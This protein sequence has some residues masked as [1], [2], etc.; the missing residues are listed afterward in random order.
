MDSSWNASS[1]TTKQIKYPGTQSHRHIH[2]A[3]KQ[4]HAISELEPRT[5]GVKLLRSSLVPL[6]L[7]AW[8]KSE[9]WVEA[10]GVEEGLWWSGGCRSAWLPRTHLSS[11]QPHNP[12]LVLNVK[13]LTGSL[14]EQELQR[15]VAPL[16]PG[17][18]R[19]EGGVEFWSC[20]MPDCFYCR[21]L[22]VGE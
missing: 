17:G 8:V 11:T 22:Y 7:S 1:C 13:C 15:A 18:G 2:E 4:K 9:E 12:L 5:C 20:L 21:S 16:Q 10:T 19:V 14:S 6:I 3:H